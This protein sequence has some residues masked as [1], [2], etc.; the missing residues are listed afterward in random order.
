MKSQMSR[1]EF[2]ALMA[3]LFATI[4]FSIDAMLPGLPQIG[5]ELSPGDLNLAQL[6]LT[7]FL[8]GMGIGTFVTGPLSDAFGR[9]PVIMLGSALYIFGAALAWKAPSLELMLFARFLQGVG[10]AGPR[11]VGMAIIRDLYEGRDMARIMSFVM[12]V[13]SIVPALAPILGAVIIDHSGWRAI[14]PAFIV[15][16]LFGVVWLAIRQPETLP[17]AERQPFQLEPMKR[18]VREMFANKM[19]RISIAVQTLIFGSLFAMLSSVQ[20]IFDTTFGRA[21]SFPAWYMGVAL[22]ASTASVVNAS[23]VMR[24]GMRKMV[25]IALAA[26]LMISGSVILLETYAE[27]EIVRFGVF[28]FWQTSMF[29]M[30]GLT[31]GNLNAMAMEPLGHIAGLVA[32]MMAGIATV[33]AMVFAVPI[34]LAFDGTPLPLAFGIVSMIFPALLLMIWLAR[35]EGREQG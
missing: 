31:L 21:D 20:Q 2:V 14:F 17:K 13:F 3:M 10:A 15:F 8:A 28:V 12:L 29:F 1:T 11:I 22:L 30:M 33:A 32:S 7:S 25:T 19:V 9:K 18:A 26:Q 34:G 6:I 16:S 27:A 35:I 5:E 24:I 4:A 23:L